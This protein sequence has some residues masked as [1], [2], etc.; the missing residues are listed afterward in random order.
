MSVLAAG[1]L[2]VALGV[3]PA[4]SAPAEAGK[5]GDARARALLERAVKALGGAPALEQVK[6]IELRGQGT[7]SMPS[8]G[9]VAVR[10]ITRILLPD[11][12]RQDNALPFGAM[13]MVLNGEMGFLLLDRTVMPLPDDQRPALRA[14]LDRNLVVL[15]GSHHRQALDAVFVGPA[16]EAPGLDLVR[17]GE[18]RSATLLGIERASGLVR[19][20]SYQSEASGLAGAM[21]LEFG[22]YRPV[23][24]IKYP[25]STAATL[26]GKPAFTFKV[27][28]V[29][30]NGAMDTFLFANPPTTV[31]D[32]LAPSPDAPP[33]P[34]P[35]ASPSGAE[36]R[37]H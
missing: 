15:L 17:V 11:R 28:T 7:R 1:G 33:V 6:S 3:G 31:A 9:D 30:V 27:D 12:Y 20:M 13:G 24:R 29:V 34:Q 14:A 26:D 5:G 16:P 4:G 21:T 35:S 37:K 23:D 2:A 19:R 25:F 32:A 18:G 22:D 10:S 36:V 8:G